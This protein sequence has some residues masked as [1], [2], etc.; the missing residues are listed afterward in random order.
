MFILLHCHGDN[1]KNS[2][3]RKLKKNPSQ[4]ANGILIVYLLIISRNLLSWKHIFQCIT[5]ISY[6]YQKISWIPQYL[7]VCSKQMDTI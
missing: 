4:S 5:T 3:P 1:E 7:I 2:G 6:V